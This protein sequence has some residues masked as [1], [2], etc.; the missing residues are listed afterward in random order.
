[1]L[2]VAVKSFNAFLT[3]VLKLIER[4]HLFKNHRLKTS[5]IAGQARNFKNSETLYAEHFFGR[6]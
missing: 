3:F 4:S 1:M 2:S 6:S 5:R